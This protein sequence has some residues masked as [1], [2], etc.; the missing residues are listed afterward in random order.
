MNLDT[1]MQWAYQKEFMI[2]TIVIRLRRA[3]WVT[4]REMINPIKF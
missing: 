3:N 1:D 4:L 2:I